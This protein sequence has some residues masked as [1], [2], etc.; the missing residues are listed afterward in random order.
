MMIELKGGWL[1]LDGGDSCILAASLLDTS[2]SRMHT[3]RNSSGVTDA[4]RE[5]TLPST[6]HRGGQTVVGHVNVN[7]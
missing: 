5:N 7:I 3:E 4:R 6:A 2:L 1:G